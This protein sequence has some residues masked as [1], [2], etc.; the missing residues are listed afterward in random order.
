MQSDKDLMLMKQT[1]VP[2]HNYAK[3]FGTDMRIS[4][5]S[6]SVVCNVIRDKPLTRAKR[7]LE[8]LSTGR[9]N[10]EGKYYTKTVKA[11]LQLINS[12][13]KNAEFKGLDTDRLFVHA[14]AHR[15]A[16]IRRRRRKGAFGS[17]LK[18]TH[19]EVLLVERGKER[20]DKV[21]KKK[22]K[23]QLTKRP[24]EQV[25]EAEIKKEEKELEKEIEKKL[26]ELKEEQKDLQKDVEKA[27]KKM[28]E[29]EKKI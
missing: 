6:A 27:E 15:G 2:K 8:D 10:L 22:I 19:L 9:R 21:S 23:E 18:N 4:Q 12:C 3:A 1:F 24:E 5:K 26:E 20:K 17:S 29:A 11:I 7:L 16:N 25:K 14:S 28:E 13:E